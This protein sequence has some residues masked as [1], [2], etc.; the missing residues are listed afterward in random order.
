[1]P[2]PLFGRWGYPAP[3]GQ[4]SGAERHQY[5]EE[6]AVSHVLGGLPESDGRVFRAH[7]LEC[8]EC[9]AR[10]GELRRIANDLADVERDE[11]RQRAAKSVETKRR[12]VDDLPDEPDDPVVETRPSPI[13]TICVIALVVGLAAWSFYL[14]GSLDRQSLNVEL[15]QVENDLALDGQVASLDP[16][17]ERSEPDEAEVRYSDDYVLVVLRGVTPGDTY[18]IYQTNENGRVVKRGA[19]SAEGSRMKLLAPRDDSTTGLVV[20]RFSGSDPPLEIGPDPVLEAT[21]R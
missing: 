15:L 9:R 7:L 14:R 17:A 3:M 11:R 21:L 10:V 19:Q 4:A 2:L 5:F 13:A 16:A 1:M 6:L 18:A 8:T 20:T 12:E